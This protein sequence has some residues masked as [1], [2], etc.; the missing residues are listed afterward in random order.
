MIPFLNKEARFARNLRANKRAIH[1]D[2]AEQ[3]RIRQQ[4]LVLMERYPLPERDY[5]NAQGGQGFSIPVTQLLS[6]R[7]TSFAMGLLV[8]VFMVTGSGAMAY[9][10]QG[11][12]PGDILYG[13]KINVNERVESALARGDEARGEIA[14]RHAERRLQEAAVLVSQGRLTQALNKNVED[15]LDK[16]IETLDGVITAL[17]EQQNY[18]ASSRLQTILE[19]KVSAHAD[20]LDHLQE[21]G[22]EPASNTDTDAVEHLRDFV[23][24]NEKELKQN[25]ESTAKQV[26]ESDDNVRSRVT[27][28]AQESATQS[29]ETAQKTLDARE[30]H[31]SAAASDQ[32]RGEIAEAEKSYAQGEKYLKD[33]FRAEAAAS[34]YH[35]TSLANKALVI[36]KTSIDIDWGA[37]GTTDEQVEG[38]KEQSRKEQMEPEEPQKEALHEESVPNQEPSINQEPAASQPGTKDASGDKKIADTKDTKAIVDQA[39]KERA[40]T[41]TKMKNTI[42]Q[43]IEASMDEIKNDFQIKNFFPFSSDQ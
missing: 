3:A 10:A 19:G 16:N 9:V 15:N 23:R 43:K 12:L 41:D 6:L 5:Q 37:G 39:T 27:L 25:I 28:A 33:G 38:N 4:L 1:I 29:V 30:E 32:A 36:M 40:D 14:A 7:P 2:P 11:S 31:L 13:V 26:K 17:N 20:I 42:R 24:E 35:A 18:E 34:F 8:G 22:K 21:I